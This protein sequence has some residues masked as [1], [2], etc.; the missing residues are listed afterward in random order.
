MLRKIRP[1][2]KAFI[3][4]VGSVLVSVVMALSSYLS[5]HPAPPEGMISEAPVSGSGG[6]AEALP[7]CIRCAGSDCV[8]W[9][10]EGAEFSRE[11][12]KGIKEGVFWLVLPANSTSFNST[13]RENIIKETSS[14]IP[15]TSDN[16][17]VT[18][19]LE[20]YAGKECAIY[21]E[22]H[23]R[24]KVSLHTRNGYFFNY[25]IRLP[26]G[27][28]VI[29]SASCD[30][31]EGIQKA[32]ELVKSIAF[33]VQRRDE[34]DSMIQ[35][36]I[37]REAMTG[38]VTGED[39]L[40]LFDTADEE[41]KSL[42]AGLL[43]SENMLEIDGAYSFSRNAIGGDMIYVVWENESAFPEWL[44]VVCPSGEILSEDEEL[45]GSDYKVFWVLSEEAASGWRLIGESS[46]LLGETC[47]QLMTY[48]EYEA[49]QP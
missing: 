19:S 46:R 2:S 11:A 36:A 5:V 4:V 29:V 6:G 35:E 18:C 14:K 43:S 26:G 31:A 44:Q 13:L 3:F 28:S 45:S 15:G 10:P 42:K 34:Q 39:L 41:E 22:M 1:G 49:L 24:E 30:G 32:R 38:S 12:V 23:V 27:S 8:I 7:N 25:L 40:G 37:R 17:A 48:E 16:M 47:P 20:G 21:E 33:S 9:L